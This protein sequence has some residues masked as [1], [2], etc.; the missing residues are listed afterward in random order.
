ME[1]VFFNSFGR[2]RSGWRF[3][4]FCFVFLLLLFFQE[5]ITNVIISLAKLEFLLETIWR[6]PL[7]GAIT[8]ILGLLIGW[9]CCFLLEGLPFKSLGL[10]FQRNWLKDFLLGTLIGGLTLVLAAGIAAI[11]GGLSFQFNQT[12]A[13]NVILT[14][15][16]LALGI[17]VLGALGEE[18]LFRGYPLQTFTRA[19]LFLIGLILT[20]VL[21]A[22]AHNGNPSANPFSWGNTFMAGIWLGIA[23]LKTRNLWFPLGVHWA[24]N[25]V[26]A[27]VLGLPVSG[28]DEFYKHSIWQGI[29]HGP[30]WLT[31]GH[32]GIEG[33]AACTIAL[34]IST[35][36]IWFAPFIKPTEE[37]LAL[38]NKENPLLP[39]DVSNPNGKVT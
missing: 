28:I 21:F 1:S 5:I 4:V 26:L 15:F 22:T 38:T 33:G 34:V 17:F 37:M 35:L 39:D 36:L 12:A 6:F 25:W 23:Y 14:N 27:S 18:I 31:G 8:S 10:S 32:Y 11:S 20:S 19:K 13:S 29:D 24:W 30:T 9:F 16:L 3:A 7:Q 2:L